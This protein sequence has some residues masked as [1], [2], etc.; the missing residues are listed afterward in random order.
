MFKN[1]RMALLLSCAI[2]LAA[3]SFNANAQEETLRVSSVFDI[4]GEQNISGQ[5]MLNGLKMAIDEINSKGGLLGKQ[6]E[7]NFYDSENSQSKYMQY[8]N[9]IAL[10][11]KPDV[12]ISGINSASREAI[13]PIFSRGEILYF[14]PELYEGGVCDRNMIA[15]NTVPSQT[16]AALVPWLMSENNAKKVYIVGADYNFGR[17]SAAWGKHYV[18]E[19]GG[20]VIGERFVP[21]NSSNFKSIIDDIQAKQPDVVLSFTVGTNHLSFYRDYA[22]AGLTETIPIGSTTFG[23]SD[24]QKILTPAEAK[25]IA[26]AFNY[27]ESD[28]SPESVGFLEK[29]KDS[30]EG[31]Q[32]APITS[33]G[34]GAW[35]SV[36]VWA[37]A[38]ERAGTTDKDK[39]LDIIETGEITVNGPAGELTIDPKTHHAIGNI[40]IGIVNEN[41]DFDIVKT[42]EAMLPA[43]EL[44]VCDLLANP[45]TNTQ[46]TP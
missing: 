38:V 40:S 4:S 41:G 9:R 1:T 18:E 7:F 44:E 25:G 31:G 2:G 34:I 30:A 8:A 10:N 15:T 17:I 6:I 13:R 32:V 45:D 14:Y 21:L 33:T 39:V 26:A 20:E 12:T 46:F 37:E 5:S 35:Y 24:E 43:Y 19:N 42:D 27:F 16:T 29:W 36:M 23:L 28:Q 3:F 22:A 11:D